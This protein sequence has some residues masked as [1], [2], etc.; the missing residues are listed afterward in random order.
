[1]YVCLCN[2]LRE[3]DVR[4]A[5]RMSGERRPAAVYAHLGCRFDCGQCAG[6]A[7]SVISQ[8]H[9]ASKPVWPAE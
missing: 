2:G 5:A 9:K 3:A 8:E 6:Y 4:S 7:R 1:M